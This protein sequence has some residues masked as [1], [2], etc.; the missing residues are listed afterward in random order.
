MIR[1]YFL[2]R[3]GAE[4]NQKKSG[5]LD[6]GNTL[7]QVNLGKTKWKKLESRKTFEISIRCSLVDAS[8]TIPYHI[9]LSD[10]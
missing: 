7:I 2:F 6:V 3:A 4:K 10:S 9:K 5:C 8:F 1:S